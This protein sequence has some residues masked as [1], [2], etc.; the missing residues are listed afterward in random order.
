MGKEKHSTGSCRDPAPTSEQRQLRQRAA[1]YE[2]ARRCCYS[3]ECQCSGVDCAVLHRPVEPAGLTG[4]WLDV[5]AKMGTKLKAI[6]EEVGERQRSRQRL[7]RLPFRSL[8]SCSPKLSF[9]RIRRSS[10]GESR[11]RFLPQIKSGS[12]NRQRCA[13]ATLV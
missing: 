9:T 11:S 3:F 10:R 7:G 5:R 8:S 1:L 4:I 13:P 2:E 6:V 12:W